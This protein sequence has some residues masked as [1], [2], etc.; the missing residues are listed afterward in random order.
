VQ[1]LVSKELYAK[2][3]KF[4]QNSEVDT[5]ADIKWCPSADCTLYVRRDKKKKNTGTCKCGTSVCFNCG[6]VAHGK[7]KCKKVNEKEME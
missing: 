7:I 6:A 4:T 2:Y 1:N 3:L 5:D